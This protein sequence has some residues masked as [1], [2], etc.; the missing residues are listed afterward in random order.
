MLVDLEAREDERGLFARSYCEREFESMGLMPVSA[1]CNLSLN[2]VRGTLRGM[3]FLAEPACEPK[4][5]RCLRGAIQDV[6]IDMRPWSETYL[7]HFSVVLNDE[8]L[9]ALYIPPMFAQGFLTL[10]DRTLVHYQMGDFYV[11]GLERGV[12]FDDP[13]FGIEW[14]APVRVVSAKDRSW[15]AFSPSAMKK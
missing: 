2:R 14:K 11:P 8:D 1:Q 7:E 3:H 10:E 4:L 9:R 6:I 15:P 5:V 12:R 13:A